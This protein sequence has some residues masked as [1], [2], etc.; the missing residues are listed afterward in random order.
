MEDTLRE[1][2][3][4]SFKRKHVQDVFEA[5]AET[6]DEAG[7]KRDQELVKDPG[8][9]K[10]LRVVEQFLKAKGRVCYGG[11]AINAHLPPQLKFYDFTKSLPDYDFFTPE[12]DKDIEDLLR[13][14]KSE[15]FTE[16][17][18]RLGIHKGTTK[19]F[20]N[21]NPVA[22]ITFTPMWMYT[23]LKKR[24]IKD[25][26]IL[27]ADADFL[28][29]NMYLELSR[30]RG[31]VERW[32]KVYKRLLLLNKVKRPSEK[33][34]KESRKSALT[35]LPAAV[36][37][38]FLEYCIENELVFAG[39]ELKKIY[40]PSSSLHAG[41]VLKGTSPVVLYAENPELHMRI[42]KQSV[43]Y[44]YPDLK[45]YGVHW[46]SKGDMFPEMY[47]LQV[48]GR[49]G[50]LIVQEQYCHSYNTVM[51]PKKRE[52]RI[53]SLDSAITLYYSL[54]Y[55]RGLEGLVPKSFQC[56]ADALVD[57]SIKVRDEGQ[58]SK[59]PLFV[60]SCHG[61]QPTKPSLIR[62]KMKRVEQLKKMNKT[63]K[64]SAKQLFVTPY[65]TRKTRKNTS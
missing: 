33:S 55:L 25:D 58:K 40:S 9:R 36:H 27:Y 48:N 46:A 62:E 15:G 45:L 61:H 41:Y 30:P 14:L 1:V 22:D 29:M 47:G 56:F 13:R 44:Q 63:K 12:P 53:A 4:A 42:L 2:E 21:F 52:L 23:N 7:E 39:A 34:C 11:M 18:A 57:I 60:V 49:L 10:A 32:D 38:L 50:I 16:A 8:L 24:A 54:S 65:K 59:F 6:I 5:L 31:E 37:N 26:G 51:V 17:V 64:N 43:K 28:R 20:V 35:K 3:S 19:I